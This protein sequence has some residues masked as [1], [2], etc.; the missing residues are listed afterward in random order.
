MREQQLFEEG[1][2]AGK[3]AGRAE[4]V[5]ITQDLVSQ[6]EQLNKLLAMIADPLQMLEAQIGKNLVRIALLLGSHLA[7]RELTAEPLQLISV[8]RDC[9][10]RLSGAGDVVTIKMHPQDASAV[11]G[12]LRE[13]ESGAA[14]RIVEDPLSSRGGCVVTSGFS[15]IDARLESRINDAIASILGDDRS[16][17]RDGAPDR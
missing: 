13:A 3:S 5:S 10:G 1:F 15:T 4:V 8:I 9:V 14:W 12:A 17:L 11:R 7:R 6:R 16:D 2:E